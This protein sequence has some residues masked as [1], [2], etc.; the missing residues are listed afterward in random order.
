M[1]KTTGPKKILVPVDFSDYSREAL[2]L[3]LTEAKAHGGEVSI[4]H[5]MEDPLTAAAYAGAGMEGVPAAGVDWLKVKEEIAEGATRTMEEL[6]ESVPEAKGARTE[7]AWGEPPDT[8]LEVARKGNYDLIVMSTHGRQGMSRLFM[9][10]VAER[11]IRTTDR[12]TL[13][14]PRRK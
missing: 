12:P 11:V 5:V 3:A 8:I 4:L 10:S 7:L 13:V 1:A 9:G 14:V 2:S 6:K